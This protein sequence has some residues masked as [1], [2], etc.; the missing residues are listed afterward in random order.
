M[1]QQLHRKN[2][3][4][5]YHRWNNIIQCYREICPAEMLNTNFPSNFSGN[6]GIKKRVEKESFYNSIET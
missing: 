4:N 6:I 1:E 5:F 3:E 2:G